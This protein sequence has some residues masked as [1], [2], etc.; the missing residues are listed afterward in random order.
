MTRHRK[1]LP[2]LALLSLPALATSIAPPF[3]KAQAEEDLLPQQQVEPP[4]S[5]LPPPRAGRAP[6]S[7]ATTGGGSGV[8]VG[9]SYS[10]PYSPPPSENPPASANV[11]TPDDSPPPP[12]QAWGPAPAEDAKSSSGVLDTVRSLF[13]SAPEGHAEVVE[14]SFQHERWSYSP[15]PSENPP[16]SAKVK[17][18]DASPPPPSQASGPAPAE[19]AYSSSGIL[20]AARSLFASVPEGQAEVVESSFQPERR[21]YSSPPSENPPAS[22]KVTTPDATPPP[23]NQ[24]R[25]YASL[26]NQKPITL[27]PESL[28]ALQAYMYP[29]GSL[30]NPRKTGVDAPR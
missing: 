28:K 13:A 25:S 26:G 16:A 6:A 23:P 17:T 3:T 14:S 19:G 30:L 15:P 8:P 10:Q 1:L 20:D 18:P 22:A 2:I 4:L 11:M 5:I 12:S 24:T 9:G 29:P 27:S 7:N 21:S